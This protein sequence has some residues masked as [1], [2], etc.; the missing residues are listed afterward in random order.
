MDYFNKFLKKKSDATA[1]SSSKE[2][3]L[4]STPVKATT[5]DAAPVVTQAP[6]ETEA[7]SF[8]GPAEPPCAVANSAKKGIERDANGHIPL[9]E[10]K[11]SKTVLP[12]KL[13]WAPLYRFGNQLFCARLCESDEINRDLYIKTPLLEGE[14]VVEMIRAPR[15]KAMDTKLLV[16]HKDKVIPYYGKATNVDGIDKTKWSEHHINK[17][18]T[19][20]TTLS[21]YAKVALIV[22]FGFPSTTE[23]TQ[24]IGACGEVEQSRCRICL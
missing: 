9:W 13:V 19:V 7:K 12:N 1:S 2:G 17:L 24:S 20:S 8:D 5:G 3:P 6:Q 11:I 4:V 21:M 16:V 22:L 23:C 15:T 10:T 14:C 18:K